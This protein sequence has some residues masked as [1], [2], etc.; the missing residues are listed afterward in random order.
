MNTYDPADAI[1]YVHLAEW[2][3]RYSGDADGGGTCHRLP[4]SYANRSPRARLRVGRG[5][6]QAGNTNADGTCRAESVVHRR[7]CAHPGDC[8]ADQIPHGRG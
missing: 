4:S 1:H 2:S 8:R 6:Q 5:R 3:A 7:G